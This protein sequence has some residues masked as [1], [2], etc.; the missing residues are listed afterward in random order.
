MHGLQR[1]P[2]EM[3][4]KNLNHHNGMGSK[5]YIVLLLENKKANLRSD[6]YRGVKR[7]INPSF[8]KAFKTTKLGL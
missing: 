7:R 8:L 4:L 2:E 6:L 1:E 3:F 5:P